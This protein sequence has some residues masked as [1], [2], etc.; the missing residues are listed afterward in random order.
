[1]DV[2]LCLAALRALRMGGRLVYSTC[3]IAPVQNDEVVERLLRRC[4]PGAIRVLSAMELLRGTLEEAVEVV[5][6]QV[7]ELLG[8][9]VTQHGAICLPD[10]GGWGPLYMA[11]VE[12]TGDVAGMGAAALLR[13]QPTGGS[14]DEGDD[15]EEEE[16]MVD[17][18]E[19]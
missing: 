9:E 17:A 19:G 3:S 8:V 7:V 2:Q 10:R 14:E 12:K 5:E 1:M 13:P 18:S 16:V 15:D 6:G 11:V 4:E